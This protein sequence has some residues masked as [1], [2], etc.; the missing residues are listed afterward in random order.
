MPTSFTDL[1]R[2]SDFLK[3]EVDERYTRAD[4]PIKNTTG[5][6]LDAGD[7]YPGC[8]VKIN[9]G[10]AE[11]VLVADI[12][13]A[14]GFLVD[15]RRIPALAIAGVTPLRYSILVR[16]PALANPDI[17]TVD[18]AGTPFVASTIVTEMQALDIQPLREPA[19]TETQTS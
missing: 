17:V 6:A 2:P 16:G 8:P 13:D 14:N 4:Y 5:A 7:V 15:S 11:T 3:W 18:P 9:A 1:P 19:T 10:N 12:A